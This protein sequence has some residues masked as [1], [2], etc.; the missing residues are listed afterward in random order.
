LANKDTK[1]FSEKRRSKRVSAPKEA[2]VI[3]KNDIGGLDRIQI[4]DLSLNGILICDNYKGERYSKNSVINNL[5]LNIYVGGLNT[6]SKFFIFIDKGKIV[7]SFVDE[8]S[9]TRC[10]GIEFLYSSSYTKDQFE[11]LINQLPSESHH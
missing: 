2:T 7:R 4:R 9:Q 10:Y 5:Y 11:N 1:Q 8:T 6:G 3:F